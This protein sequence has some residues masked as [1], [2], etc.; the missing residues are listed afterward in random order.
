M[1]VVFSGFVLLQSQEDLRLDDLDDLCGTRDDRAKKSR[2]T[3][4]RSPDRSVWD[5]SS[6]LSGCDRK[7]EIEKMFEKFKIKMPTDD[8]ENVDSIEHPPK[9]GKSAITAA[10]SDFSPAHNEHSRLIRGVNKSYS[11]SAN[12]VETPAAVME[13]KFDGEMKGSK[14][15]H[16]HK[17]DR[18]SKEKKTK[19]KS[20]HM[21]EPDSALVI[22]TGTQSVQQSTTPF[23]DDLVLPTATHQT[24][25]DDFDSSFPH[26]V[27]L[28]MAESV[29]LPSTHVSC[30]RGNM[31][32]D[33]PRQSNVD[34][35]GSANLNPLDISTAELLQE[36]SSIEVCRSRPVLVFPFL[37]FIH[38]FTDSFEH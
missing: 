14:K 37:C 33:I 3:R 5:I 23:S 9:D 29:E 2:F 19:S 31:S 8:D 20:R 13:T 27:A 22:S 6:F 4:L 12:D 24:S 21:A 11:Y 15:K 17:K 7:N 35:D 10:D 1:T 32:L 34:D 28:H 25:G 18:H 38:A 36:T 16:K 30:Q 26:S